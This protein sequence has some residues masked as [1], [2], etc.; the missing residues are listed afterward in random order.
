[1]V[2]SFCVLV[3]GEVIWI[4]SELSDTNRLRAQSLRVTLMRCVVCLCA[5]LDVY[6]RPSF[7]L[8]SIYYIQLYTLYVLNCL[9]II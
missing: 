9:H 5:V 6:V 1:M 2:D 7:L 3:A 8:K 4:L